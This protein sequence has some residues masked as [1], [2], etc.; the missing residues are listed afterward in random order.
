[1]SFDA[2]TLIE[3]LYCDSNVH[4]LG[5]TVTGWKWRPMVY[6]QRLPMELENIFKAVP[7]L[8]AAEHQRIER[9]YEFACQAHE[10]QKRKSGEPYMIHCVAV[11]QT[12][13]ELHMD[14]DTI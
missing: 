14:A 9:A 5:S 8:S 12:L 1:M 6:T 11:A 2:I 10:G 7:K 13:A 3:G 4:I